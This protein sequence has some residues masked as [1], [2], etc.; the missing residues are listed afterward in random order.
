MTEIQ[1]GFD[2]VPVVQVFKGGNVV[3]QGMDLL[4]SII[5]LPGLTSDSPLT[6]MATVVFST[7]TFHYMV[8]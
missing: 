2:L 5:Y 3:V 1:T 8:Q 6:F 4:F 7:N